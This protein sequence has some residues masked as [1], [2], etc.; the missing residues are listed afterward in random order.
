MEGSV[1][2]E[3]QLPA[4]VDLEEPTAA[5]QNRDEA[6]H[7]L[8][9]L[10]IQLNALENTHK[11]HIRKADAIPLLRRCIEVIEKTTGSADQEPDQPQPPTPAP[12]NPRMPSDSDTR[13]GVSIRGY[14]EAPLLNAIYLTGR[15]LKR[16]KQRFHR[17]E[18][19]IHESERFTFIMQNERTTQERKEELQDVF[20]RVD[21]EKLS[22]A[23]ERTGALREATNESK[24]SVVPGT[25]KVEKPREFVTRTE[26]VSMLPCKGYGL[27]RGNLFIAGRLGSAE[28]DAQLDRIEQ[29][30]RAE[31]LRRRE[32]RREIAL[33]LRDAH[34]DV[35]GDRNED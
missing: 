21:A 20:N 8:Q 19:G 3:P 4:G 1:T 34:A 28:T 32:V 27:P 9:E 2:A 30:Q 26:I 11:R 35:K 5:I 25:S 17:Q 33:R 15:T 12:I 10:R 14:G 31:D 16:Q 18:H 29:M 6:L 13:S 24:M 22:S 7:L 23:S